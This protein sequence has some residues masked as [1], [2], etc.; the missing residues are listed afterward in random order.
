MPSVGYFYLYLD[1]ANENVPEFQPW[2]DL[3]NNKSSG[4]TGCVRVWLDLEK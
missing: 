1:K 4:M 3:T 2:V